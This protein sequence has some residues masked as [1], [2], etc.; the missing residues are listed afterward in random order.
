MILD[1]MYGVIESANID[2][3]SK[4][5][6]VIFES[7]PTASCALNFPNKSFYVNLKIIFSLFRNIQEELT[8]LFNNE[9]VADLYIVQNEVPIVG[10][11]KYK[12]TNTAGFKL[13]GDDSITAK[14]DPINIAQLVHEADQYEVSLI[15]SSLPTSSNISSNFNA[16]SL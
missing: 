1:V 16:S 10:I 13:K 14:C 15:C 12:S 8:K 3:C 2:I 6:P 5:P 7:Q 4:E 9:L 11:D